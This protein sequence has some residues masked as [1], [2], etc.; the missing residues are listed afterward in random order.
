MTIYNCPGCLLPDN[1]SYCKKCLK[2]LFDGKK[3]NHILSFT[4]PEFD[5]VKRESGS[6]LSLSGIQLKHSLRL[7]KNKLVLTEENGQYILKPISSG[8]FENL[9]QVPANEHLTMQIANQVYKLNTAANG[10]IFFADGE[11]AFI[12]RRFDVL[13]TGKRMLQEDF[14]QISERTEDTHGKNYKYDFS[15][16]E[17]GELIKK[18]VNAYPVEIEKYFRI[19]LFNYLFSNGDA[20]LKNFSLYRSE[21]YGDYLLTPFYDLINTSL[22]V[23]G[24]SDLALDMFKEG[25]ET[26]SYKAS[27]KY[28]LPDFIEFA[29]RLGINEKRMLKIFVEMLSGSEQVK[30]L[31]NNSFLNDKLKVKYLESYNQKHKRLET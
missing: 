23:P 25:F 1:D 17:I 28:T 11:P 12:S 21:I 9:D 2:D 24:E 22:H 5:K 14:A 26:K 19:I 30:F 10:I 29:S 3:V 20:H 7:E 18:F 8:Q 6:R 16:E 4:R 27:S 15:Y 31:I 13:K